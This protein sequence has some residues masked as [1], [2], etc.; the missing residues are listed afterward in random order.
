MLVVNCPYCRAAVLQN[1]D[2]TCPACGKTIPPE[3][4]QPVIV[5]GN[6]GSP[7]APSAGSASAGG[8]QTTGHPDGI[9]PGFYAAAQEPISQFRQQLLTNTPRLYVTQALVALN[10]VVFVFMVLSGTSPLSPD[11]ET[12]IAWGANYGPRTLSGEWWRLLTSMFLHGGL[13]HL[14]M[15]MW[16]L[17]NLGQLTERLLGN[18]GFLLMYTLSGLIGSLASVYWNPTVLSVGASGAIFGVVGA[19]LAFLL[20]HGDSVPG[21]FL[22]S[23]KRMGMTILGYAVVMGLLIPRI[24]NAA[25]AGGFLSGALFGFIMS[26]PLSQVTPA[27]RRIR[28]LAVLAFGMLG[29]AAALWFAPAAPA[30]LRGA[31]TNLGNTEERL[32]EVYSKVRQQFGNGELSEQQFVSAI[33]SQVLQPWR[34]ERAKFDQLDLD[35]LGTEQQ[36]AAKGLGQY[37]AQREQQWQLAVAAVDNLAEFTELDVKTAEFCSAAINK[38]KTG[39]ISEEDLAEAIETQVLPKWKL[40]QERLQQSDFS[41]LPQ[42]V[43]DSARLKIRY[44]QLRKDAWEALVVALKIQDKDMLRT[45]NEKNKAA[46]EIAEQMRSGQM[47]E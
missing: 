37:L 24:D 39:E 16:A 7:H 12:L 18:V 43:A 4:M 33:D 42:P 40:L 30:D 36:E 26:Q 13:L 20:P 5:Q 34:V 11:G 46:E 19:L 23:L 21:A 38:K 41:E 27:T 29:L 44:M 8:R 9:P 15:N 28:N 32:V 14:G 31:L 22:A 35:S 10:V 25:H 47:N 1:S 6:F 3:A 45:F 2:G 17:W